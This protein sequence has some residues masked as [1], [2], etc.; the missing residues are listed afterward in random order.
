MVGPSAVAVLDLWEA[1]ERLSP[2]E[3]SLV[4]AAAGGPVVG[5]DEL[6]RLP[7]GR[8][9]A[10]L[11]RLRTATAGRELEAT[12]ACPACAER[13][14]FSVDVDALLARGPG[15]LPPAPVEEGGYVVV[16]RPPDSRD[17]A[18]AAETGN[19]AAAE[20]LLLARCVESAHGPEGEVEGPALP[21]PVR[22]A[23]AQAMA[24]ADPLAEVLVD[25]ACPA[26]ET[27]FVADLDL[28]A[29]VWADLSAQACRLMREVDVL[30]RVYGWTEA[31]ALALG[32]G[33][34]SAYL[35]LASEGGR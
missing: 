4:L 6:A 33:R 5:D 35:E 2:V 25:L 10:R 8:R 11:L 18:A 34:R 27:A 21:A 24:D 30:A 13:A 26:C 1:A 31:E 29:F 28:G 32:E 7:L 9:D 15:Q 20:R 23:L 22:Q 17:M 19:A 16:W 14:E 12:A 3:R